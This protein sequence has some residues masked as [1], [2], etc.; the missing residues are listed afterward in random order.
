M[1][2]MKRE[3]H[4]LAKLIKEESKQSKSVM[5]QKKNTSLNAKCF[6]NQKRLPQKSLPK[7]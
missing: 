3:S 6:K 7:L 1:R 4:D 5:T 2:N